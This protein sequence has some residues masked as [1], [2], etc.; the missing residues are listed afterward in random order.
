MSRSERMLKTMD[1]F[2][3]HWALLKTYSDSLRQVTNKYTLLFL[4]IVNFYFQIMLDGSLE[5]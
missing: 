2:E 3:Q 1:H 4:S 5:V